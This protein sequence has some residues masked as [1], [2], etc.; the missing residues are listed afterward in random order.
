MSEHWRQHDELSQ[1]RQQL[2]APPAEL[3]G[4]GEGEMGQEQMQEI[5]GEGSPGVLPFPP[6]GAAEAGGLP[7]SGAGMPGAGLAAAFG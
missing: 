2:A 5:P 3:A 7:I 6:G 4:E 1:V